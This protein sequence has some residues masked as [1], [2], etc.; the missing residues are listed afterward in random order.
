[1]NIPFSGLGY[2]LQ[3]N[4]G[5]KKINK[6]RVQENQTILT[7]DRT[8]TVKFFKKVSEYKKKHLNVVCSITEDVVNSRTKCQKKSTKQ[9]AGFCIKD[10]PVALNALAGSFPAQCKIHKRGYPHPFQAIRR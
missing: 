4:A 5:Y 6:Q 2:G 10:S 3:T 9:R 7:K 8:G 1:M